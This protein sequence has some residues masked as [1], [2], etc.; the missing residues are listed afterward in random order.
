MSD[1]YHRNADA[2]ADELLADPELFE[3]VSSE[4][5]EHSDE[6]YGEWTPGGDSAGEDSEEFDAGHGSYGVL[7]RQDRDLTDE[8]RSDLDE[9]DRVMTGPADQRLLSGTGRGA[10]V[11]RDDDDDSAP[12]DVDHADADSDPL[13]IGAAKPWWKF[14]WFDKTRRSHRLAGIGVAV[15]VVLVIVVLV[16]PTG[17]EDKASTPASTTPAYT[18]PTITQP[19]PSSPAPGDPSAAAADGPI[20]IKRADSRCTAGS[21][22]PM[23]AFDND[24]NTAWMCVPAYGVPGTVLRVEFDNWY[25]ITGV[26]IVPGWNRVN[27]DGSDEWLKHMTAG[28]VEY[29]FN[30]PDETRLTQPTNN[31]RDEVAT[32]VQP[33]V[34]ASAMTITITE[35]GTP[36][37]QVADTKTIPGQGGII[38]SDTPKTGDLRDFAVSSISIIGH[39]AA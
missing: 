34:L 35:F 8:E 33:P 2:I 25:V 14:A 24:V 21:S 31:I 37:G 11:H 27:P 26:S 10:Y 23:Q 18:V 30:D 17:G 29:Q 13:D 36:T 39:R 4:F 12:D 15:V 38:A 1:L 19:A 28:T 5:A 32:P 16:I 6:G 3:P 20:G 9:L 22:N 7:D